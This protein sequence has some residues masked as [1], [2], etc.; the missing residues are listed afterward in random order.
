[1]TDRIIIRSNIDPNIFVEVLA[2]SINSEHDRLTSFHA[3]YPRIV[4]AELNTHRIIS[5]NSSSS[6]AVPTNKELNLVNQSPFI[7]SFWGKNQ[8][9]MQAKELLSEEES[10]QCELI[11][12]QIIKYVTGKVK[13]FNKIGL[14]KQIANRWLET[15]QYMNTVLTATDWDN[16]LSLRNHDDAE[17]H[18]H[19]LAKCIKIALEISKPQLLNPGEWHLPFVRTIRNSEGKLE[20]YID[21]NKIQLEDGKKISASCCAQISYRKSDTSLEKAI[22]L[23]N[24]FNFELKNDNPPHYSPTQHQGTP[25]DYLLLNQEHKWQDTIG[26]THMDRKYNLWSEAFCGWIM[27]R[28]ELEHM[29]YYGNDIINGN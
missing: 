15:A 26:I 29:S 6:R 1:M 12:N 21:N 28:K 10:K 27:Y 19:E 9:G 3:H 25:V 20:Y 18:L 13:L 24:K 16:F 8:A 11:W 5:K 23:F 4:L 7:P 14:H 22:D 2:D 17:P